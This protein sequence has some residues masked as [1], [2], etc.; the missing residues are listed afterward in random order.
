MARPGAAGAPGDPAATGEYAVPTIKALLE[1]RI[2]LFGICLG[3]QLLGLNSEKREVILDSKFL[4]PV[5]RQPCTQFAFPATAC[6]TKARQ[7]C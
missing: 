1:T 7:D 2:P 5:P 4:C 3:H 6:Q